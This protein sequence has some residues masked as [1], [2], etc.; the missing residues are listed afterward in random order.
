MGVVCGCVGVW[1][2]ACMP[3][4][5]CLYPACTFCDA[6]NTSGASTGSSAVWDKLTGQQMS[7]V[8]PSA[9]PFLK[10]LLQVRPIALEWLHLYPPPFVYLS[11][12]IYYLPSPLPPTHHTVLPAL[13][14]CTYVCMYVCTCRVLRWMR[15]WAPGSQRRGR[16]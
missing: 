12:H 5:V 11:S 7:G 9:T 14:I 1:A 4:Q 15:C 10:Q 3:V 13:Y 8:H 16:L 6:L 2:G